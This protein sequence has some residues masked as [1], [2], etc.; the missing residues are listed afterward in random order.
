MGGQSEANFV[1]ELQQILLELSGFG[2]F[3][4]KQRGHEH[5]FTTGVEFGSRVDRHFGRDFLCI[6]YVC[7]GGQIIPTPWPFQ[8][9]CG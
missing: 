5:V 3:E 7:A 6:L 9:E 2:L 1:S 8:G 4:L